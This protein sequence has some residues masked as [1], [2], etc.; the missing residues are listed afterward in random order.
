MTAEPPHRRYPRA[1]RTA[2]II[3]K[4]FITAVDTCAS[5]VFL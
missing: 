4:R 1:A 2:T 3:A 5:E